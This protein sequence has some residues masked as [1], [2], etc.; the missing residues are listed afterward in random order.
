MA[1]MK[2]AAVSL[3]FLHRDFDVA[4][5]PSELVAGEAR[6]APGVGGVSARNVSL[7]LQDFMANARC[8]LQLPAAPGEEHEDGK[9]HYNR[10]MAD[11][12]T[13]SVLNEKLAFRGNY[14]N[15]AMGRA[16]EY[17]RGAT[18][19]CMLRAACL[20]GANAALRRP[21]GGAGPAAR[22]AQIQRQPSPH[23]IVRAL[24]PS[25]AVR[26]LARLH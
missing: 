8:Y 4:A 10:C 16:N 9:V 2:A 19:C 14:A 20:R 21:D 17:L 23:A 26:R 5:V 12:S 13:L 25:A 6:A 7:V 1:H 18:C 22:R 3:F 15:G 24:L 11:A